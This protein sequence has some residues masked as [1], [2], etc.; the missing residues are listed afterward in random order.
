MRAQNPTSPV[1]VSDAATY[2]AVI[3]RYCVTCHNARLKTGGLVLEGLD[4]AD[5][6]ANAPTLEKVAR[7]VRSRMMPPSGMPKPDD[8]VRQAFVSWLEG[9]LDRHA[10]VHP[11]PG[12]PLLHRLNRTE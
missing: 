2:R 5:L 6:A 10:R 7:R 11:N 9:S 4:L 12:K 3:D 1:G 8:A